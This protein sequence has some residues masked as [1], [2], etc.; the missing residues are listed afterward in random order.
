MTADQRDDPGGEPSGPAT[1]SRPVPPADLLA[2]TV[3]V[4]LVGAAV[5]GT[6]WWNP[7][8]QLGP[9]SFKG[10]PED[11]GEWPLLGT[12]LAHAGPG[13]VPAVLLAVLTICYGPS[14]AARLPWRRALVL[15]YVTALGWITSLALVDGWQRGFAGRLTPGTEYLAEVPGITD[16]PAMLAGFTDRIAHGQ[17][18]SWTVHVAGHPPGATLVFVWLDRIGLGGGVAASTVCVLAGALAAVAVP[19]TVSLLGHRDRAR[20]AL[21]LLV[22]FPGAVWL[23]VSADALFAGVTATGIALLALAAVRHPAWALP[24]GAILGFGIFLSYG[25]ITLGAIA[26]AVVVATRAW[27]AFGLAVAGALAVVGLFALGGFWWLDGYHAVVDRYYE[28]IAADRPY[29]FWVWANLGCLALATGPAIGPAL[30]RAACGLRAAPRLVAVV[31][32][33][34]VTVAAADLSGLSKAEVER[35]WLPFAVWLL[36]AAAFLPARSA[37]W[38][39]ALQ[40][41]TALAVNHLFLTNW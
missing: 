20:T 36:A 38:W 13:T 39:L 23:G 5:A 26:L 24:A 16:I 35:I 7:A 40:A 12:P 8:R 17:P 33:A 6:L 28:G 19:A 41:A 37:R 3:V 10:A 1:R 34:V 11:F 2:A 9:S 25:L 27:R 22:L 31:A 14:L 30:R 15:G 21:P 18:D 29:T 4:A 32:G